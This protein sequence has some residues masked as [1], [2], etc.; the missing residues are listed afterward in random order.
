MKALVWMGKNDV[1]VPSVPAKI[2]EIVPGGVDACIEA[3]GGE[4]AKTWKHKIS[5]PRV[6]S[7]ILQR[8]LTSAFIRS[9]SLAELVSLQI[10]LDVSSLHL[11]ARS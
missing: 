2:H 11:D 10:T 7:R 9:G 1:R 6:W 5:W 4:Y 8:S 3:S